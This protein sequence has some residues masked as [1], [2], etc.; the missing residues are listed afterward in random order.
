MRSRSAQLRSS[1]MRSGAT[2]LSAHFR[3]MFAEMLLTRS[4]RPEDRRFKSE[5]KARGAPFGRDEPRR[6][7]GFD[8]EIL[9][10]QPR[11]GAAQRGGE[12]G[13]GRGDKRRRDR[14]DDIRAQSPRAGENEG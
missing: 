14:E 3:H 13:N 9:D 11:F 2:P 1:T 12:A 8:L 6:H 10:V 4:K 7:R 5:G